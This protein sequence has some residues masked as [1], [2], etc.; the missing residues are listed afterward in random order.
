MELIEATGMAGKEGL[1]LTIG[2]FDGVHHGHQFLAEQLA[3]VAKSEGLKSAILTFWPHP[4]IIL[5]EAYQPKLLN[6]HEEKLELL[7]KLPVDY[8][9]QME[10][11]TEVSNLSA[12][13]FMEK[14]LRDKLNV[15]HLLIGYDHRFGKNREE[16]FDD[17]CAYG[18]ELG[19]IV[20][21]A[22]PYEE[23]D[24]TISSSFIRNLL[25]VGDIEL[26]NKY[27]GYRYNISGTVI[28]GKQNGRK[29]GFPTANIEPEIENKCIPC[30][31]VFAVKVNVKGG[32]YNGVACIGTRPT[33]GGGE[34]SIEVNIFDFDDDIY[35]EKIN[36][37]FIHK[38]R[39]Q[40]KFCTI[41]DLRNAISE[42]R[43]KAKE[44]LE[45]L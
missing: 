5:H 12:H 31:G 4:R 32:N 37:Q 8:C 27:L 25:D 33:F 22:E 6:T 23:N 29:L 10:F 44:I 43:V 24:F 28:R 18:E 15:K 11:T 35:G 16:G 42:D 2:F 14:V 1:A 34:I 19:M 45:K 26:A 3:K 13:D 20:T 39:A 38:L 40:N 17:Y 9:I 36:M 30:F 41:D 7:T 21:R